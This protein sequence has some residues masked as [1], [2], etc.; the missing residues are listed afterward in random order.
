MLSRGKTMSDNDQ[1]HQDAMNRFIDLA[2][3]MAEEGIQRNLVGAALLNA[4]GLYS[5]YVVGGNTGGLNESGIDKLT[6]MFRRE[7]ERVES[8]KQA[9]T[10]PP[11]S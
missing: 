7:L 1:I 3:E 4:A 9:R 6:A 2:N 5:S 11:A 10:P 8:A